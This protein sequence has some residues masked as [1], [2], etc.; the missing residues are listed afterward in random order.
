MRFQSFKVSE[1]QGY[2]SFKD[3]SFRRFSET[4]KRCNLETF[5]STSAI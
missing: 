5:D 2:L 3:S 4:L 1:F